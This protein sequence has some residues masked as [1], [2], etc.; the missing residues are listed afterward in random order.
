M[1]VR[2][3]CLKEG[4]R[5][6]TLLTHRQGWVPPASRLESG[7]PIV[8][9]APFPHQNAGDWERKALHQDVLVEVVNR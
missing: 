5:F 7:H 6:E 9:L 3:R 2:A 1:L 8:E 4:D